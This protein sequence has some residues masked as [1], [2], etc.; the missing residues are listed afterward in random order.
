M[1]ARGLFASLLVA[2]TVA[3]GPAPTSLRFE[4]IS[5]WWSADPAHGGETSHVVLRFLEKDGHPQARLWLE[6]VGAYDI[7][8]GDI[9]LSGDSVSPKRLSFPLT[10]NPKTQTLS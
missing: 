1:R 7:D 9:T 4:D 3:A 10:L 8:L 5:G 6:G 2:A